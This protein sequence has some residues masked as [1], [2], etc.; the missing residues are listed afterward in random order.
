MW[1]QNYIW[2]VARYERDYAQSA[3]IKMLFMLTLNLTT[4]VANQASVIEKVIN[5]KSCC[6][7]SLDTILFTTWK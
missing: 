2:T 4:S 6:W 1:T 3:A 5:F 7:M